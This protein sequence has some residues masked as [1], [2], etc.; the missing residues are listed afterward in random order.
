MID[1]KQLAYIDPQKWPNRIYMGYMAEVMRRIRLEWTVDNPAPAKLQ[2]YIDA[3]ETA[4]QRFDQDYQTSQKSDLTADIDKADKERDAP[5]NQVRTMVQAMRKMDGLP[6][7][8]QAAETMAPTLEFY[9]PT[10]G[11]A[12]R[13]ETTQVK[14]WYQA[15]Q[16]DPAQVAAA[17]E[18]GLTDIIA[19]LMAKNAEVETLMG[20]RSDETHQKAEIQ[21]S[22]DRTALDEAMDDMTMM[23][24]A[25]TLTDSHPE[26]FYDIIDGLR[27]TQD[28]YIE[29]Y[30]N[31]RRTN[32]RV[33]VTSEIVGNHTYAVSA[34]WT[35]TTIVQKNPKAF[36]L[37]PEPSAPGEEPVVTAVRIAS[38]DAKA[39]KAGG[40]YVAL[41]GVLV[42]PNA[43][44]DASKEYELVP[45][46]QE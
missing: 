11:M 43:E 32:K 26:R 25:C 2:P 38:V 31:H 40:L 3:L 42:R 36:A 7:K 5:L 46:P 1:I 20:Q 44:V 39:K 37:D 6:T 35:W 14:Q 29:Q 23:L 4:Y 33:K 9:N 13:D 19:E 27:N 12:L 34:G 41:K 24:N 10:A 30:E 18:L 16:A 28:D 8:K 22:E 21:L 15:F 45:L 17:A